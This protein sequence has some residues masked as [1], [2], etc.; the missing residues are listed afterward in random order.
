MNNFQDKA[1]FIWQV[2]DDIL[3]GR[4]AERQNGQ[5]TDI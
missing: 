1:N 5:L 3:R 2:A 4:L